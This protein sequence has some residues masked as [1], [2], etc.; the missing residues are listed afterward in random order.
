MIKEM[1]AEMI[2]EMKAKMIEE[3]KEMMTFMMQ[4]LEEKFPQTAALTDAP[5]ED[6]VASSS[7]PIHHCCVS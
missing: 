1:K 3:R 4:L 2:E 5:A 7:A 6:L